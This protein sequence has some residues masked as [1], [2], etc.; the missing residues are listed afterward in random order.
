MIDVSIV[1]SNPCFSALPGEKNLYSAYET[2]NTSS[3]RKPFSFPST[4]VPILI[5]T[6]LVPPAFKA[7]DIPARLTFDSG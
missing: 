3:S 4:N 6:V 5:E 7:V 2:S 1:M